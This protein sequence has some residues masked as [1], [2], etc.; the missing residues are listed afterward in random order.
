MPDLRIFGPPRVDP[1][2]SFVYRSEYQY[3]GP[4]EAERVAGTEHSL[5]KGAQT[6]WRDRV[7]W[8]VYY[9]SARLGFVSF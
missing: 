4:V 9:F 8:R 1:D 7:S 5:K 6:A 3:Y 2:F